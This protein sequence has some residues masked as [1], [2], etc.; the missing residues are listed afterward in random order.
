[1]I[2]KLRQEIIQFLKK[3]PVAHLALSGPDGPWACVVQYMSA[4]LTMYLIERRAS[5]LVF[6]VENDPQVVLTVGEPRAESGLDVQESGL[7][8]GKARILTHQELREI[9]D[10]IQAAYSLRNQQTRGVY[11]LIE[12]Q[13]TRVHL[14][15]CHGGAIHQSTVDLDCRQAR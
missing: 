9:P 5:D 8:F 2:D 7:I 3:H 12:V 14:V 13:P 11:T 6:Y 10:E 4:G 1:M 15:R